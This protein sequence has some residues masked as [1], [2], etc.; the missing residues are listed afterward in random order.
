LIDKEFKPGKKYYYRFENACG[1]SNA[2]LVTFAD[3]NWSSEPLPD[4]NPNASSETSAVVGSN[5]TEQEAAPEVASEQK[6]PIFKP[7]VTP[8][9]E[10]PAS[11]TSFYVGGGILSG[12]NSAIQP[13]YVMAGIGKADAYKVY[14]RYKKASLGTLGTVS[15][16]LET[17]NS[18]ITNFPVNTNTYYIIS[19]KVA[20][21]RVSYTLGYMKEFRGFNVY[22]GG[23]MGNNDVYWN[24]QTFSYANP[25]LRISDSWV[26]N[27]VQS[28][29]G[30]EAEV[31]GT[32]KFKNVNLQ[33]G[34]NL[35]KGASSLFISADFGVGFT[36]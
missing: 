14:L 19:D 31:G 28:A 3:V 27:V 30:L 22:V 17:N 29:N 6:L 13:F 8:T 12:G 5:Q 24:A 34:I 10:T 32:V 36:F 35:I 4:S 1:A 16:N 23:G 15:S 21:Q 11:N 7:A 33:G 9:S 20:S 25:G 18:K 2:K 26:K